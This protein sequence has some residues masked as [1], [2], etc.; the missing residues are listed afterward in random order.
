VTRVPVYISLLRGINIGPHNRVS[1]DRLK[2]SLTALGF[3]QVQTYIQSGNVI[4]Q[5]AIRSSSD[6]STRIEKKIIRDFGLVITVVS[7]TADEMAATIN[8]NPF[9]EGKGIDVSK[10]HVTFLSRV[11]VPS[12][13]KKLSPLACAG[14]E[15]RRSGREIY[16]YCPTGYG[17]TKLSNNALEKALSVRATTRNWK[18]VN[19]LCGIALGYR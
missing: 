12:A 4:F 19:Q 5:A 6:V 2:T 9:L 10:L 14:D 16:L 13:L 17:R 8:S 3:K 15:F 7:R 18:T 1:M 11:P